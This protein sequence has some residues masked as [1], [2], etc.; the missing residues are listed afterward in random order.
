[1]RGLMATQIC[2]KCH[3]EKEL[4]EFSRH[5]GHKNGVRRIC[6]ICCNLA[7]KQY[8]ASRP[9]RVC[10]E[11]DRER[12]RTY[13]KQNKEK[14]RKE[15]RRSY[16]KNKHKYKDR[17]RRRR[18]E[19]RESIRDQQRKWEETNKEHVRERRRHYAKNN[20]DKIR[21][22]QRKYDKKYRVTVSGRL[23]SRISALVR[24]SL[25]RGKGGKAT[26]ELVGWTVDDL[27]VHLERQFL[28]NMS[29]NNMD[30]WQIDHIRPLASFRIEAASSPEFMDAWSLTNLR[31]LW[32]FQNAAKGAKRE[33]LI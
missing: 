17:E 21:V 6:K 5:R 15:T 10:T 20:R 14:A 23:H 1:M 27:K 26:K 31:P 3:G 25:R 24:T 4:Q 13:R 19:N 28:P 9:K 8:L 12:S 29:W 32:S 16:N 30:K 18:I 7:K 2:N 22:N 11:A 33:Y